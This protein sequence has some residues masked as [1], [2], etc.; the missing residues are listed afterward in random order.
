MYLLAGTNYDPAGAVSKATSSLLAMTAFDTTNLRLTFTAPAS[1]I[2]RV[3][4]KGTMVG[5]TTLPTILLGV[6]E[7]AAVVGRQQATQFIGTA[8]VATQDATIE[9]DFL[10]TGI[11]AGSHTYDAAYAVQ[12]VVA[13]TNIKYG[14]P[15]TNGGANAW[16][17][18]AFEIY[19]PNGTAL[20]AKDSFTVRNNTA[21]AGAASTITLDAAA[22]AVDS[23]YNGAEIKIDTG[24]GAGQT[25]TILSYVGSTKVATVDRAWI[26][27]PDSTS[28]FTIFFS[29][30]PAVNPS[31]QVIAA[32]VAG[33]V[34]SVTGNV[35]GNVV[36]TVAG[37]TPAA[38]GA[39]M[40]IA[41]APSAT[42]AGALADAFLDRAAGVE[43]GRTLR[44]FFRL[45]AAALLGKASGLQTA[46]AKY[47]DAADTKDRITATVDANGNRSAVTLDAS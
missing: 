2:V 4:M 37:V 16:G 24:T 40:D 26:T 47:R 42:G 45:A 5:A 29:S 41:D 21:Q 36:G 32:S 46:T 25:R 17:G 20:L 18:F 23:F 1:G 44:Q 3:R 13:S 7:A 39:K 43:T 8:N 15:N 6:L 38:V 30:Q 27:N 10:I 19:D 12:V 11:A 34:G 35:G 9:A 22:S 31:L 33:A 14:G 28:V